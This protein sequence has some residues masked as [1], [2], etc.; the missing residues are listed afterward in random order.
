MTLDMVQQ[1]SNVEVRVQLGFHQRNDLVGQADRLIAFTRSTTDVPA[2][3]GTS[4]TW[5]GSSA[6]IKVHIG[7]NSL[8]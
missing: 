4:H 1:Q 7:L 2:D 3:G 8:G 6:P 5:H